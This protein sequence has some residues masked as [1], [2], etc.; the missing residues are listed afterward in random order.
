M[1]KKEKEIDSKQ[2]PQKISEEHLA[3]LQKMV[4]T[5]NS[6]QFRIGQIEARKH[7]QLHELAVAQDQISMMQDTL[8]KEYGSYDIDLRDGT[9]TWP[10]EPTGGL[11]Y[12]TTPPVLEKK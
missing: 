4:N 1:A 2:K 10:E 7:N 3:Q 12:G 6:V 11:A 5:V 8:Q 9:I